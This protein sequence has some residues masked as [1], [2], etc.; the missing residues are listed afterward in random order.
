MRAGCLTDLWLAL[1][2]AF[3][4]AVQ[5]GFLSRQVARRVHEVVEYSVA[6]SCRLNS[7]G[8]QSTE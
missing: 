3:A 6:A 1:V 7:S 5:T 2:R 8:A 4:Q